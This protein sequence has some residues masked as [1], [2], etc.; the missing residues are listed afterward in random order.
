MVDRGLLHHTYSFLG[1][2]D[3]RRVMAVGRQ[4]KG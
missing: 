2:G 1:V 4:L 3:R